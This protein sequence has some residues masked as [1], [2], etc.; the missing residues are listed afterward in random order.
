MK[1]KGVGI[2]ALI[3][4]CNTII[5]TEEAKQEALQR[6]IDECTK[7]SIIKEPVIY[8]SEQGFK[9]LYEYA[10][11]IHNIELKNWYGK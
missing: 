10:K 2:Q 3:N 7:P 1:N 8:I 9:G 5:V 4:N 11:Q 6:F